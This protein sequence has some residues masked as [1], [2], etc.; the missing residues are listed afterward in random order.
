MDTR[1]PR[2]LPL[3]PAPGGISCDLH[4]PDPAQPRHR[5]RAIPRESE[6]PRST[7]VVPQNSP[8]GE[9]EAGVGFVVPSREGGGI[10]S[11]PWDRRP[12]CTF[13]RGSWARGTAHGVFP[14]SRH[15]TA[16]RERGRDAPARRSHIRAGGS[17]FPG[18]FQNPSG[19]GSG[20]VAAG[21]SA[22]AAA[23]APGPG[24]HR[25]CP[26]GTGWAPPLPPAGTRGARHHGGPRVTAFPGQ[27]GTDQRG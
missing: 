6:P 26:A 23:V 3:P 24:W 16:R 4:A 25:R 19:L 1:P 10:F 21:Y 20:E 7:P 18:I 27:G 8:V 15:G 22:A 2:A 11:P 5:G 13:Q 14:G 17:P 12:R 9:T